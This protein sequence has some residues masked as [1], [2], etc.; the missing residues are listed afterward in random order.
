MHFGDSCSAEIFEQL[1]IGNVREPYH[2]FNIVNYIRQILKH[3]NWCTVLEN[4]KKTLLYLA[5][6]GWYDFGSANVIN[7]LF[8]T[9]SLQT[10]C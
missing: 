7:G 9:N 4:I 10:T 3:S 1:H 8:T 6:E 2:S 5:L